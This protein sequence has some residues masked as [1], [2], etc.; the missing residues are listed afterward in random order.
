LPPSGGLQASHTAQ[1]LR[2]TSGSADAQRAASGTGW[3][4]RSPHAAAVFVLVCRRR[5]PRGRR[6]SRCPGP[7]VAAGAPGGG[8]RSD[9]R[10]WSACRVVRHPAQHEAEGV[11]VRRE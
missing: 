4:G 3:R 11:P 5:V 7:A 8:R 9:G 1:G 6:G 10:C 2:S